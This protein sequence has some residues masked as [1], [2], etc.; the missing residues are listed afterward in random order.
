MPALVVTAIVLWP[1]AL[2]AALVD[3]MHAPSTLAGSLVYA[4]ASRVCHQRPARSYA[5]GGVG[6]PVC[7]R[8]TGIYA[9]AAVGALL[10]AGA[11]RRRAVDLRK[12]RGL[13]VATVA[14]AGVAWFV[15]WVDLV[16]VTASWRTVSAV[17]AGAA[18]AAAVVIMAWPAAGRGESIG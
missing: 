13:V 8:C 10:A 4:A 17:P 12:L 2:G 6:W 7:T 15:E 14:V 16:A 1:V 3:R 11:R 18:V 5:S 9:G